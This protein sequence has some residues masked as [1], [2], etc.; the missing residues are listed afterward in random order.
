MCE[1]CSRQM[2]KVRWRL[3]WLKPQLQSWR[4]SPNCR[5]GTLP[6]LCPGGTKKRRSNCPKTERK[7]QGKRNQNNNWN[8]KRKKNKK[9]V[10]VPTS[11]FC[12]ASFRRT[13]HGRDNILSFMKILH[14]LDGQAFQLNPTFSVAG[15]CRMKFPGAESIT[16]Q[17]ILD[18]SPAAI[19]TMQL[20]YFSVFFLS[21]ES[22]T[23]ILN[24]I[25]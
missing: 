18:G 24:C 8:S 19:E 22:G 12:D 6:Q 5:G 10:T 1:V 25:L 16:W 13:L 17:D 2:A 21:I 11:D 7:N 23:D 3:F 4:E 14:N 15:T 9:K 20:D